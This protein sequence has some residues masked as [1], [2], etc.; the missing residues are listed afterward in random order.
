M[1]LT[2]ILANT[3]TIRLEL[4]KALSE[5]N[6]SSEPFKEDLLELLD[7]LSPSNLEAESPPVLGLLGGKAELGRAL[8]LR[9][10][11]GRGRSLTLQGVGKGMGDEAGENFK[12]ETPHILKSSAFKIVKE[13]PERQDYPIRLRILDDFG[14]VMLLV[15]LHRNSADF[16]DLK[17]EDVL[18]A[19]WDLTSSD[20]GFTEI[21]GI[22]RSMSVLDGEGAEDSGLRPF[23]MPEGPPKGGASQGPEAMRAPEAMEEGLKEERSS[24]EASDAS[25]EYVHP[26][27]PGG[28]SRL[29]KSVNERPLNWLHKSKLDKIYWPF[30]PKVPYKDSPEGRAGFLSFLWGNV[31]PLT[32]LYEE[33][34]KVFISLKGKTLFYAPADILE[35]N[36]RTLSWQ[37]L[38][39]K[40]SFEGPF[41]RI[42]D[43]EG[44][45][46]EVSLDFLSLAA[47]EIRVA[48]KVSDP[49]NIGEIEDSKETEGSNGLFSLVD[50]LV[51]PDYKGSFRVS[52]PLVLEDPRALSMAFEAEKANLIFQE[53]LERRKLQALLIVLE[54]GSLLSEIP[55]ETIRPVLK[56]FGTPEEKIEEESDLSED[57]E[58]EPVKDFPKDFGKG[59]PDEPWGSDFREAQ[60]R[61][62]QG[63]ASQEQI[64]PAAKLSELLKPQYPEGSQ[65]HPPHSGSALG[66]AAWIF[67]ETVLGKTSILRLGK[68]DR[69]GIVLTGTEK[70]L[71]HDPPLSKEILGERLEQILRPFSRFYHE[72]YPDS[73]PDSPFLSPEPKVFWDMDPDNLPSDFYLDLPDSLDVLASLEDSYLTREEPD[74]SQGSDPKDDSRGDREDKS[75]KVRPKAYPP[76]EEDY[77]DKVLIGTMITDGI[78]GRPFGEDPS[79]GPWEKDGGIIPKAYNLQIRHGKD[80]RLMAPEILDSAYSHGV[81]SGYYPFSNPSKMVLNLDISD[82]G[83]DRYYPT[84]PEQKF[85]SEKYR[86]RAETLLSTFS[87]V[88]NVGEFFNRGA[89]AM[90]AILIVPDGSIVHMEDSFKLALAGNLKTTELLD[91][92]SR[93]ILVVAEKI[94][95]SGVFA[96][97][98][99]GIMSEQDAIFKILKCLG[100]LQKIH[101]ELEEKDF[102]SLRKYRASY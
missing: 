102:T 87:S 78:G 43:S 6:E 13:L 86:Q 61:E 52:S 23:V 17:K 45:P 38:G 34:L 37:P 30:F 49:D 100:D 89:K 93:M 74:K 58:W 64:R 29:S 91:R 92:M 48:A 35:T 59:F 65:D 56:L 33:A 99:K 63:E 83:P 12:R 72:I 62:Y 67:A 32:R 51:F 50:F 81:E 84:V 1:P 57:G 8:A 44:N 54:A 73:M 68:L 70:L 60:K 19:R 27:P 47:L 94:R 96:I 2:K 40:G 31:A 79:S 42:I 55:D 10:A 16:A 22:L 85:V 101:N 36:A 95:K 20:K 21:M 14:L 9:F 66:E 25:G 28:F 26:W 98:Q 76:V 90:E 69:V 77:L 11:R 53:T 24:G 97:F 3:E 46:Y 5:K 75:E 15:S 18:K 71:F 88:R 39:E 80:G 4:A 41:V 82:T 7:S